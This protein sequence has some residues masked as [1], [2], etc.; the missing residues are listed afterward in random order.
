MML[1]IYGRTP[2]SLQ[3]TL[4]VAMLNFVGTVAT[5]AMIVFLVSAVVLALDAP[6]P[7]KLVLAAIAGLWAGLCAAAGAAGWLAMTRPFPLIGLFVAAPL[8]AAAIVA[9]FPA[10][11]HAMLSLPTSLIVGLNIPRLLRVL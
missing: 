2:R 7:A 5:V 10:G 3:V 8:I 1:N 11:R 6:R 9:A 4:E